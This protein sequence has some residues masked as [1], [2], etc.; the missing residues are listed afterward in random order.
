M[1]IINLPKLFCFPSSHFL[2]SLL[3]TRHQSD[4]WSLCYGAPRRRVSSGRISSSTETVLINSDYC[5]RIG[6]CDFDVITL[7]NV[8]QMPFFIHFYQ[9]SPKYSSSQTLPNQCPSV[10]STLWTFIQL[11]TGFTN[12]I[13][14]SELVVSDRN[15]TSEGYFKNS[16]YLFTVALQS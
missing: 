2:V 7:C 14:P 9:V 10:S 16:K 13:T 15:S 5:C 6:R 11:S 4:P 3:L 12:L 8:E 1:K